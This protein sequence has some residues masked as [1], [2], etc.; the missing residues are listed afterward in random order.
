[1]FFN[2]SALFIATTLFSTVLLSA[3]SNSDNAKK[4]DT[5]TASA[6]VTG[7]ASTL[8]ERNNQQ[9]L[10][11]TLQGHL[12][13]AGIQAKILDIKNTEVPN[14]Y[15]ITLEGMPSV[16]A[17]SDGKY[18]FQ[19]EIIRLGGKQ[20][21]NVSETLQANENKALFEQLKL[22]DLIVYPA[23]GKTKHI[24]Y[25]FTDTSCPYCHKFHEQMNDINSKG[26]EVR[27]IAWPR[28]EQYM[29]MMEAVWCSENRKAAFDIAITGTNFASNACTNPVREQ[30]QLGM[31]IGVQGT[32]AVYSS[33][34]QYLG[35]YMTPSELVERLK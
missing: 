11:T 18:I 3:C 22:K 14:L 10:M 9:R 19:G 12:T 29:P 7:E 32:P 5:L 23:Q 13:Q 24:I 8:S 20:L 4:N 34:G 31:K 27:Y 33:N 1:M 25:V 35:G 15:W 26:I 21:H 2:R 17:T 28:G 30:Y 16:Y 6:P